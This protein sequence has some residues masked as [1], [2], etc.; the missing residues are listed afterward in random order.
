MSSMSTRSSPGAPIQCKDVFQFITSF[1]SA[2]RRLSPDS[3][4]GGSATT[5]DASQPDFPGRSLCPPSGP[6][7]FAAPCLLGP[8]QYS[9]VLRGRRLSRTRLR[10]HSE[11]SGSRKGRSFDSGRRGQQL[12]RI[13]RP[14]SGGNCH[15]RGAL[16]LDAP[17]WTPQDRAL[18]LN[19][20]HRGYRLR[21]R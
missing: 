3:L 9:A 4:G 16:L 18:D 19:R 12:R 15:L 14:G 2:P 11:L 8:D 5:D 13:R 6:A 7:A 10:L 20:P 1:G 17:H 21:R